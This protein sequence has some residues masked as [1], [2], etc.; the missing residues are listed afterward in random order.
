MG[1]QSTIKAANGN[2]LVR[3]AY[4]DDEMTANSES[5]DL[6]SFSDG[7]EVWSEASNDQRRI[8]GWRLGQPGVDGDGCWTH[9]RRDELCTMIL[10]LLRGWAAD[11]ANSDVDLVSLCERRLANFALSALLDC[12]QSPP[13]LIYCNYIC[14]SRTPGEANSC[15][16]EIKKNKRR[17]K[18]RWNVRGS[19]SGPHGQPTLLTLG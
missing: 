14:S 10:S 3:V 11:V 1:W 13:F 17:N 15:Q 5:S 18:K 12:S 6:M 7:E 19:N 16:G 4:K 8:C 2:G 9:R